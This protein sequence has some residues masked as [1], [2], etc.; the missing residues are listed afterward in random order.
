MSEQP[1]KLGNSRTVG[2][3]VAKAGAQ[4]GTA[5][6]D[7]VQAVSGVKKHVASL[8]HIAGQNALEREHAA[9]MHQLDTQRMIHV[10]SHE[11]SLASQAYE[12]NGLL[13]D[14]EVTPNSVRTTYTDSNKNK[15]KGKV[16]EAVA[17]TVTSAVV[18]AAK[19]VIGS[20]KGTI[21]FRAPGAP[22]PVPRGSGAGVRSGA[23]AK[24][25]TPKSSDSDKMKDFNAKKKSRGITGA[26]KVAAASGRTR[27]AKNAANPKLF[28]AGVNSTP[29]QVKVGVAM[30]WRDKKKAN[31][32][33]KKDIN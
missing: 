9:R 25:E 10:S 5:I 21:S 27:S 15:R 1:Y 22:K 23:V 18:D 17:S 16:A 33:A 13:R 26:S 12:R 6:S 30:A 7:G 14:A 2:D 24:P 3:A 11:H 4:I 20:R 32:A 29:E 31:R 19:D 8:E 28:P